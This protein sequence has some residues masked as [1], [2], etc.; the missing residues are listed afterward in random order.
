MRAEHALARAV[1]HQLHVGLLGVVAHHDLERAEHR[2]V[3]VHLPVALARLLLGEADGRDV[4]VGEHG[5]RHVLVVDGRRLAAEQRLRE[6][7]RFRGRHR[8][9][10]DAVGD[11]AD[12]VDGV[13]RAS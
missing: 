9:E 13:D 12:G 8:R 11:I 6:P 4:R 10:V 1:D 5:G 3:D 2:L 7:H